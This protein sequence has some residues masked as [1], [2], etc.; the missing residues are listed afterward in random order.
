MRA[1]ANVERL[2]NRIVRGLGYDA[3][4]IA[5]ALIGYSNNIS[6]YGN[7]R[8]DSHSRLE[9]LLRVRADASDQA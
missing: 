4:E 1:F 5:G 8:H 2:A 7:A 3:D 9:K 6:I